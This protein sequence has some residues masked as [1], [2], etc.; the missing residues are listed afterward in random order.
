MPRKPPAPDVGTLIDALP[1]A[2]AP[3][4]RRGV[5]RSYRKGAT[6]IEEGDSGD[7][8]HIILAGRLR[9]Y[10]TNLAQDREITYGT[11]GPGEYVGELGLDGQP[12]S[13]SVEALEPSL[14]ALVTRATLEAHIAEHPAFAFELLAKVISRARAATF[15]ARQLALN[16]VYGRIKLLLESLARPTGAQ[17]WVDVEP[18]VHR[19]IAARVGCSR[20]MVSRVMKDLAEGKHVKAEDGVLRVRF[21][22]P[23]RW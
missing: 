20:E 19:D 4:A 18:M 10:S 6:L 22:L 1:T 23:A 2:L 14:C 5:V 12:R 3:L 9:A 7:T 13:A 17:G 11:Y 21:P 16:D 15:T 8:L